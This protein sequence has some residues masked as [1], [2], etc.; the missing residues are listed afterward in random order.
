M[1]GPVSAFI[2]Q[3]GITQIQSSAIQTMRLISNVIS[4]KYNLNNSGKGLQ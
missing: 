3:N 4:I 1:I 2:M